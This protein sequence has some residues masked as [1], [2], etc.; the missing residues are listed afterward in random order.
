MPPKIRELEARLRKAGFV[1]QAA[2]GSHR[3]WV[4]PSG[5]LV[6]MSGHAGDDAKKY[7]EQ[8]VQE[9]LAHA[10]GSSKT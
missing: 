1:K 3:K 8:I 10:K 4:H 6:V 7:Q 5:K 2:S 9:A